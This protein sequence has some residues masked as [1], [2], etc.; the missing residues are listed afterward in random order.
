MNFHC[1]FMRFYLVVYTVFMDISLKFLY[2][3]T[4]LTKHITPHTNGE[5]LLKR[6][7]S[8]SLLLSSATILLVWSANGDAQFQGKFQ[9]NLLNDDT[10][11]WNCAM[12]SY[13][14]IEQG[15]H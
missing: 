3:T 9:I 1:K 5:P 12:S 13:R 14:Q 10:Y 4:R 15:V 2:I 6:S 7:S 11:R 8:H